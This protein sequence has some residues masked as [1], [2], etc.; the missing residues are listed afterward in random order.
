MFSKFTHLLTIASALVFAACATTQLS[1]S[2][3]A[4]Y[5]VIAY[6]TGRADFSRISAEKLT[7]INYAF[8][9]VNTNGEAFIRTNAP[10]HLAQLQALKAR[11]PNLKI[12]LSIGGWGADNFS[13]A[14][15]SDTS[16]KKFA[17]SC[18][19]ILKRYALDGIDLDWEYPGQPGPGIKFRAEDKEN[20][21]A[22]CRELRNQL[23]GLSDSR[24]R[25]GDN[26]YTLT[27]ASA[28]GRYFEHTEMDKV[29]QYLDWINI[30]TYDLY[31]AGSRPGHHAGLYQSKFYPDET[32]PRRTSDS[33]VADH[34]RATIP[35][36]KLVLGAAFYGKSWT[37]VILEPSATTGKFARSYSYA[38]LK[39]DILSKSEF[40]SR[41]DPDAKASYLWNASTKTFISYEGPEAMKVKADYIKKH[42]LGGIMFWEYSE[43]P[44]ETLLS[45]L[46]HELNSVDA[47]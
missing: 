18:L 15:L 9:L 11:N 19:N 25:T 26:R 17:D 6:V 37:N 40:E 47:R 33:D 36:N 10:S 23:D 32:K 7:H 31:G 27:I 28:G 2:R 35:P 39:R 12:I 24:K 5:K 16:R 13:D 41:W 43:D 30:M 1:G 38:I 21:T 44:E 8:G 22:M 45:T 20:F 34:L 29:Q 42:Q 46:A 14:A 4:K 3:A